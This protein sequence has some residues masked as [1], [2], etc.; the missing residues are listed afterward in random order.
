MPNFVYPAMFFSDSNPVV[1][2]KDHAFLFDGNSFTGVPTFHC[3]YIRSNRN[4]TEGQTEKSFGH[5]WYEGFSYSGQDSTE[6][7]T[8]IPGTWDDAHVWAPSMVRQDGKWYMVYTGVSARSGDQRIGYAVANYIDT[9]DTEWR[10]PPVRHWV[11]SANNTNTW[12]DTASHPQQCRDPFVMGDPDSVGR[13]LMYYVATDRSTHKMAV[14]VARSDSGTLETWRDLGEVEITNQDSL[15]TVRIES[16]HVF[17]SADSSFWYLTYTDGGAA[18]DN[19]I[20]TWSVPHCSPSD[21]RASQ[22][23]TP[24]RFDQYLNQPYASLLSSWTASEHE[25][26]GQVGFISM[27]TGGQI[28]MDQQTWAVDGSF[29]LEFPEFAMVGRIKE[30]QTP[31]GLRVQELQRAR[32]RFAITTST[33]GRAR[34]SIYDLAGRKIRTVLDGEVR[35]KGV[36]AEWNLLDRH[37]ERVRGGMYFAR[38]SIGGNSCCVRVPV[39]Q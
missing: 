25:R 23:R 19:L 14:G 39:F 11:F 3:Y 16:P 27:S 8:D 4:L 33:P 1:S 21:L 17:P 34:L 15:N 36:T 18:N 7:A 29:S 26:A 30:S 6:F 10:R 37:G 28:A 35:S 20:I 9:T 13:W 2:P 31:I 32:V 5:L 12:A 24:V 22:W 38:L